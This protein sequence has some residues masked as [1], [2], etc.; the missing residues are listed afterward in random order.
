MALHATLD[1]LSDTSHNG[2]E[3]AV[4]MPGFINPDRILVNI[5]VVE[6]VADALGCE[7]LRIIAEE[8]AV[9]E[10]SYG[11]YSGG[12][13]WTLTAASRKEPTAR[14][15]LGQEYEG[16]SYDWLIFN[17]LEMIDR[18]QE[19]D[20]MPRVLSGVLNDGDKVTQTAPPEIIWAKL[21]DQALKS[22]LRSLID[23]RGS[24]RQ[25]PLT[26]RAIAYVHTARRLAKPVTDEMAKEIE[27]VRQA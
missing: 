27:A 26:A 16:I 21:I 5:G 8:G 2:V 18:F 25:T 4:D 7:T 24:Q 10:R 9:S 3:W 19:R 6:T 11:A 20:Y 15:V 1:V 13:S 22:G 14:T 17:R 12:D 23:G